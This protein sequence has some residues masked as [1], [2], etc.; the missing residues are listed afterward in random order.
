MLITEKIFEE[1]KRAPENKSEILVYGETV[2]GDLSTA[3]SGET[4]ELC[5]VIVSLIASFCDRSNISYAEFISKLGIMLAQ[6][7]SFKRREGGER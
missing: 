6:Y 2:D 3:M 5:A 7:D 1:W 4:S